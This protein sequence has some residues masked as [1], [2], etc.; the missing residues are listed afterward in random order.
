MYASKSGAEKPLPRWAQLVDRTLGGVALIALH[1]ADALQGHWTE[2]GE[3]LDLA[4][5]A[6]SPGQLIREQLDLLQESRSRLR[7]DQ[8][9]RRQLWRGLWKDVSAVSA[10]AH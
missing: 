10:A 9:I 1:E 8:E 4:R 3:R 2:L 5:H 7:H 6:R